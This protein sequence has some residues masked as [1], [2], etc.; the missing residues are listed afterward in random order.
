MD[1][2]N[3]KMTPDKRSYTAFKEQAGDAMHTHVAFAVTMRALLF[4]QR[5]DQSDAMQ[6]F[7][8]LVQ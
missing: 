8:S 5:A 6:M 3:D 2:R 7:S 1:I 4:V